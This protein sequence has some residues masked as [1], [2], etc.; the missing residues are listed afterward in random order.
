V[1]TDSR[2]IHVH[3]QVW[4]AL[5]EQGIGKLLTAVVVRISARNEMWPLRPRANQVAST[6]MKPC[7]GP[8]EI[9]SRLGE[10]LNAADWKVEIGSTCAGV[11]DEQPATDA[12]APD[13][14]VG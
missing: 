13:A 2:S 7:Q 8:G 5:D 4:Q 10:A 12:L 1:L 11:S 9:E 14:A 6:V 3:V